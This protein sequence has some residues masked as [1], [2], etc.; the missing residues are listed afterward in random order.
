MKPNKFYYILHIQYLGF[1]FHGWAKQPEVK[2]VHHMIDRTL[3][4]VFGHDH[5]K[6]L[7]GSRTD[8]MVSAEDFVLELFVNDPLDEITFLADLNLSLPSDIRALSIEETD[9][10]FNI[11]QTPKLKQYVYLF[12]NEEKAHPFAAPFITSIQEVMDIEKIE[13]GARLFQ[14]KHEFRAYC[15][16]PGQHTQTLR[17]IDRCELINNTFYTASFFPNPSFAVVFEG[18]GFLRNQIR[19]IVA[20]LFRL[21]KG[22]ID[23]T[24]IEGSLKAGFQEHLSEVAPASGLILAKVSL[25]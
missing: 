7:G 4:Y 9:K 17:T 8:A 19:M 24:F 15:K 1:R 18:K 13:L 6:T 3:S 16:K 20:Q 5:F 22:E 23:L 12:A 14:G 2:T 11:I 10:T 25:E 21:G